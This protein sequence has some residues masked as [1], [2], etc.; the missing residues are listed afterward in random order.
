MV[1]EAALTALASAA[2]SSQVY[3]NYCSSPLVSI[4]SNKIFD[5]INSGTLPKIL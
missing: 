2:D 1:Q 4:L 3:L 5:L